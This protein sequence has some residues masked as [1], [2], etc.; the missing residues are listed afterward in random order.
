MLILI[1]LI[2]H[3]KLFNKNLLL[4]FLGFRISIFNLSFKRQAKIA[5]TC[6]VQ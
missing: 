4:L 3:F 1:V 5:G 6:Y 2:R